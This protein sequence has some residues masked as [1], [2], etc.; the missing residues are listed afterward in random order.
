MTRSG[1]TG[2]TRS[3]AAAVAMLAIAAVAGCSGEDIAERVIERQVERESGE[4]VDIDLGGGNVRIETDEGTFEMRA[5]GDGQI[6]I[7]GGDGQISIDSEDGITVI[8]S[9]DGTAVIESG[10]TELP[11]DF[12]A[13]VPL[14]DGFSPQFTQSMTTD[15]G[16]GWVLS[17]T[18]DTA[19]ADL[20]ARYFESL[21]AAGFERT[22]VTETPDAVFF[23][24]ESDEYV[25]SGGAT[26]DGG[27]T[28]TFSLT[29]AAASP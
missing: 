15:Q 18:V 16:G 27:D 25:V 26:A 3:G 2:G 29:V 14:P 22:Q 19:P 23:G 5:D 20:A 10:G 1:R 6:S 7:D 9:E 4:E 12:P 21:A 8:E 11:A 13:S 17:G 24:F 28:V